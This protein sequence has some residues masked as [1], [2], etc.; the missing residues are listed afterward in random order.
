MTSRLLKRTRRPRRLRKNSDH[1]RR[2][3]VEALEDRRL[4]TTIS[5]LGLFDDGP[6]GESDPPAYMPGQLLMRFT[7]TTS[8]AEREEILD[9]QGYSILKTYNTVDA[10][11]V[12]TPESVADPVEVLDFWNDHPNV[13]YAEPDFVA[14]ISAYAE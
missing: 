14:Y 8:D 13:V 11:L 7:D 12:A 4:L 3:R 5:E 9:A 2:L 10:I 1:R 6:E